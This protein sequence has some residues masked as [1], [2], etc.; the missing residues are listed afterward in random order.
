M[1]GGRRA[2]ATLVAVGTLGALTA[3]GFALTATA[4]AAAPTPESLTNCSGVLTPDSSGLPI[5]E[6]N[7]LDY[8]FNCDTQISA[9]TI[10]L[11]RQAGNSDNIDDYNSAP[12]VLDG[13]DSTP[14]A[15][16]SVTCEGTTPSEGIN[17]NLGAGGLLGPYNYVDGSIDPVVPYCKFLP[18][19]AKP[20]TPAVPQAIVQL[21]VTDVTG[22]QDGPFDLT[23]KTRCPSVANVV[24]TPKPKK[25]KKSGSR[26][27]R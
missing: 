20:G 2:A 4:G 16:E 15:T 14:N 23:L 18:A 21:I 1:I 11:D 9:Y 10:I 26:D 27:K 19:H 12:L 13:D 24:P 5:G 17:C 7:L 6:P 3:A 22:A 8:S 25:K